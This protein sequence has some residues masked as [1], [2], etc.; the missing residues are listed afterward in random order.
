MSAG[1]EAPLEQYSPYEKYR[2]DLQK[3]VAPSYVTYPYILRC[4]RALCW[5][6]LLLSDATVQQQLIQVP[7]AAGY[8]QACYGVVDRPSLPWLSPGH[9]PAECAVLRHCR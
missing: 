9:L 5:C 6:H 8:C 3:D 7:A 2:T 1:V 4:G